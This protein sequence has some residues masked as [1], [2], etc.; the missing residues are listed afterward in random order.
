MEEVLGSSCEE[1]GFTDGITIAAGEPRYSE[2][3]NGGGGKQE[4]EKETKEEAR[5]E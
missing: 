5:W 4:V 3:D 1:A 2:E